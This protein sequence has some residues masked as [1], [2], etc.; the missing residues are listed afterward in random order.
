MKFVLSRHAQEQIERRAIPLELLE[1]VLRDPQ[2]IVEGYG[3]KKT[4]QS[5]FDFGRG[6]MYLLR[7]ILRD[8]IDPGMVVTVYKTSKIEKYWRTP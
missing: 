7:A 5:Q 6:R 4:Y 3:G 8:D 2:Q 1:A